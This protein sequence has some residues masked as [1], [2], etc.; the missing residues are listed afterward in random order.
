MGP[1]REPGLPRDTLGVTLLAADRGPSHAQ[2][3]EDEQQRKPNAV[4]RSAG[5]LLEDG[6]CRVSRVNVAN[7][8]E[9][10]RIG[11]EGGLCAFIVGRGAVD[12]FDSRSS[13][14]LTLKLVEV[15]DI[16]AVSD[17]RIG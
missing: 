16:D 10:N 9:T 12:P 5:A 13:E 6:K 8:L 4:E 15:A 2:A 11:G 3:S 14:G 17:V 7:G 1:W